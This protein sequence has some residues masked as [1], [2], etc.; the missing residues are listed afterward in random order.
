MV[1]NENCQYYHPGEKLPNNPLG[2]KLIGHFRSI[3]ALDGKGV[4]LSADSYEGEKDIQRI[5][6]IV[7]KQPSPGQKFVFTKTNPAIILSKSF[8]GTYKIRLTETSI[9]NQPNN[10]EAIIKSSGNKMLDNLIEES[11]DVST[12]QKAKEEFNHEIPLLGGFGKLPWNSNLKAVVL[13]GEFDFGKVNRIIDYPTSYNSTLN[14]SFESICQLDA[15]QDKLL[16]ELSSRFQLYD[17]SALP[18]ISIVIGS[19]TNREI[20]YFLEND[21]LYAV[22]IGNL[23]GGTPIDWV[24]LLEA[25]TEKYGKPEQFIN[26]KQGREIIISKWSTDL[27]FLYMSL[28]HYNAAGERVLSNYI[29][30]KS[31]ELQFEQAVENPAGYEMSKQIL[32]DPGKI[33]N[34]AMGISD[35]QISA[36]EK[37]L[38]LRDILYISKEAIDTAKLKLDQFESQKAQNLQNLQSKQRSDLKEK[39]R[40]IKDTI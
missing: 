32:G 2:I 14:Q 29:K 18:G 11:K 19:G 30:N 37:Q 15:E 20:V 27:G 13:A 7:G 4:F 6:E 22:S 28:E 39:A 34:Q 38:V 16:K 5:F 17:A 40:E 1:A 33:V 26:N 3:A 35:N 23:Q 12:V 10:H 8:L 24:V 25:M 36:K 21:K 9:V 31:R